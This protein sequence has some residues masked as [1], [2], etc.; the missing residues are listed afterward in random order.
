M[1]PDEIADLVERARANGDA[2]FYAGAA[3]LSAMRRG[4]P[5][6]HRNPVL[7]DAARFAFERRR[8]LS[9]SAREFNV[10]E[11]SLRKV[12]RRMYPDVPAVLSRRGAR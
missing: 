3:K 7:V 2:A 11:D 12:W 10:H 5:C 8:T 4:K 6:M 9:F 1:T